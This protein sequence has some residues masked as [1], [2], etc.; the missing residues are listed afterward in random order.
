[1]KKAVILFYVVLSF[2]FLGCDSGKIIVIS[3]VTKTN[4]FILN[5]KSNR[6]FAKN[7]CGISIKVLGNVKGTGH[8][9]LVGKEGNLELSGTVKTNLYSDWFGSNCVLH[10]IPEN[11]S[12]GNI[13]IKYTFHY[14]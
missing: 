12:S 7:T 13:T 3:D 9:Y 11:V 10:Y 5:S 2:L 8:L 1:M 4:R 14:Y 6:V